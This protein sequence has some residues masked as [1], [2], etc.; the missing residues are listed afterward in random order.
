[1]ICPLVVDIIVSEVQNG[2]CLCKIK[3]KD[4]HQEEKRKMLPCYPL[5][6]HRYVLF[7]DCRFESN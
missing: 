4:A 6:H 3:K 1:M 7:H 5:K 2:N